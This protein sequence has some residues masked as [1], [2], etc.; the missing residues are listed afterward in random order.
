MRWGNCWIFALP[1]WWR[2]GGALVVIRS[3]RNRN[4]P[5]AMWAPD[6]SGLAVEEFVPDRPREGVFGLLH[7]LWFRGRVRTRTLPPP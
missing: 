1:R 4:I 7:S 2:R 5:H 3:P 6:A